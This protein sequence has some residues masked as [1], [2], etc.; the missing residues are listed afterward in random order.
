MAE[1]L[2][3]ATWIHRVSFR[4]YTR[5]TLFLLAFALG[6]YVLLNAFAV[7]LLWSL[8]KA[9]RWCSKAVWVRLETTPFASLL[10]NTGALFGL[11]IA[12]HLPIG[13]KH[14]VYKD[15]AVRS[16]RTSGRLASASAAVLLLNVLDTFRPPVHNYPL[17]YLLTF[18]KSATVALTTVSFVPYCVA[19]VMNVGAWRRHQGI[20]SKLHCSKESGDTK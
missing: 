9:Q 11:G 15:K 18:C 10:R 8:A 13:D 17:Y 5:L 14:I 6:L 7:D 12:L 1:G 3:S 20:G 19:W 4:G 16:G 2:N